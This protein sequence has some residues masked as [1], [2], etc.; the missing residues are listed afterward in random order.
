[1]G[2]EDQATDVRIGSDPNLA[3]PDDWCDLGCDLDY[4]ATHTFDAD[5][6]GNGFAE[7]FL[8]D[9]GVDGTIEGDANTQVI[10]DYSISNFA[11]R[12]FYE[13]SVSGTDITFNEAANFVDG[14]GFGPPANPTA[15]VIYLAGLEAA[16]SPFVL[17]VSGVRED[18]GHYDVR[19]SLVPLPP[20]AI[21]LVSAVIGIVGI[22][23]R[24]RRR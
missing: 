14:V 20:A 23:A 6:N 2:T 24:R 10:G 21:L 17:R 22:G 12:L 8:I 4:T 13:T 15:L 7:Y 3:P 16:D 9:I 1:L 5:G 18:V 11:V 19:A